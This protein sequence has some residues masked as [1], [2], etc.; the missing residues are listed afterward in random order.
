L[1]VDVADLRT[2]QGADV[3]AWCT[4]LSRTSEW[5]SIGERKP[6]VKARL[7]S[8]LAELKTILTVRDKG[9]APCRH[10]R[11]LMRSKI[12]D[13]DEQIRNLVSL[14][15]EMNDCQGPGTSVCA[16]KTGSSS[17]VAGGCAA[18][19]RARIASGLPKLRRKKGQ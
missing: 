17:T 4:A 12:R 11:A 6:I 15:V 2:H 18:E 3:A 9:G 14:R 7:N 16:D 19:T 13:I 5:F 8:S 1:L 10:V